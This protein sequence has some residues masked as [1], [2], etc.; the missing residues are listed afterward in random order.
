[1]ATHVKHS[2]K[3]GIYDPRR[4]LAARFFIALAFVVGSYL[5]VVSL[6]GIDVVGCGPDSGCDK[7]LHSR[8]AYWFGLPVSLFALAVYATIFLTSFKLR[9]NVPAA[10][11][12][13]AWAILIPAAI[14][15]IGAG[16]W[17]FFLQVAVIKA[18]CPFCMTAH[19]SGFVASVLLLFCAPFGPVPEKPWQREK[20][21]FIPSP[22]ISKL[23]FAGVAGV[24]VLVAGQAL[25][26]K[27]TGLIT[28]IPMPT[29]PS[30]SIS[31]PS[32][33]GPLL[34]LATNQPAPANPQTS[35]AAATIPPTNPLVASV[36]SNTPVTPTPPRPTGP[37]PPN[38][39]PG[40]MFLV[41]NTNMLDLQQ[42]P[43]IG[44]TNAPYMIVSLFDYT[45]HHC[46]L[47]HGPLLEIYRSFSNQLGIINLPMPLDPRC[48]HNVRRAAGP[49]TNACDY[50]RLGLAVW[51]ANRAKMPEFDNWIFATEEPPS[52]A[53]ARQ[54]A[55]EL[56]GA[57][58][59]ERALADPWLERQL[60]QDISIYEVAY[61][62]HQGSMPQM[63]IGLRVAVGAIGIQDLYRVVGEQFGL[64]LPG[65]IA[66]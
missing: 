54:R 26:E 62:A 49:H 60:Q 9:P 32:V 5:L 22:L 24:G 53:A 6:R 30:A 34:P 42:V 63:I 51:R 40:R 7:V 44:R 58:N 43:V 55:S 65:P 14:M 1:M 18:I 4:L 48:N 52:V 36:S 38:P 37:V 29:P 35:N 13:Q 39:W 41:Y 28:S 64:K 27:K 33:A 12:R 21:V 66:P 11:Q 46:K 59:L 31:N 61:K 8:W 15:V 50:A 10:A 16:L 25:H 20:Q 23:V 45:C 56:V 47:M 17:F 57:D 2:P 3:D 19:G